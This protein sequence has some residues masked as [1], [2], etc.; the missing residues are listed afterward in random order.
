MKAGAHGAMDACA[1]D[2]KLAFLRTSAVVDTSCTKTRKLEFY[3]P[4]PPGFAPQG[5]IVA[6][7]KPWTQERPR[8]RHLVHP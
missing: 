2:L 1:L 5:V 4:A 3:Y 7:R 6:A 8:R